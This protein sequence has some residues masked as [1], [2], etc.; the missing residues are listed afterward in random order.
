M[1]L[2]KIKNAVTFLAIGLILILSVNTVQ[3]ASYIDVSQ[4]NWYFDYVQYVS[5]NG[6][7]TG[8]DETYFGVT[9]ELSRAQFAMILYRLA[10]EPEVAYEEVFSDVGENEWYTDAVLWAG[11]TGVVTGYLD[12]Q[13]FGPANPI[14]RE[15]LATMI[16]RFERSQGIDT[17]SDADLSKFPDAG[18]VSDFALDAMKWAVGNKIITGDGGRLNPQNHTDRA[19]CATMITRYLG[20][21]LV[22]DDNEVPEQKMD[23]QMV[24]DYAR[25]FL[26]NPYKY[27]GTSLT[28]GADCSGFVMSVYKNFGIELGR[29]TWQQESAGFEIP[30]TEAKPG[31]LIVYEGHIGIYSGDG[32]IIHS[33]SEKQG[34]IESNCY[35]API[36]TVRR[37]L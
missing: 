15:E 19:C 6:I 37:V 31:D 36:K 22:E 17:A 14:S 11:K 18:T 9:E 32:K 4:G 28:D 12:T 16:F 24:V 29:T 27:G 8:L 33:A 3:A 13:T 30:L 10:G 23:G 20:G 35:F 5:D 21:E 7:M 34:I 25:Q 1:N 26:G 2:K